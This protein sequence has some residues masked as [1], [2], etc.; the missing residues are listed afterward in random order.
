MSEALK[1]EKTLKEKRSN[2]IRVRVRYEAAQKDGHK[3]TLN[4]EGHKALRAALIDIK[5]TNPEAEILQ[6]KENAEKTAVNNVFA[7]TPKE[8]MK[9]I[10][11]PHNRKNIGMRRVEIG[12]R[13]AT[14]LTLDQFLDAS[15]RHRK[16]KKV[17]L[18]TRAAEMQQSHEA[19]AVCFCVSSSPKKF[20]NLLS[21]RLTGALGLEGKTIVEASWQ[22]ISSGSI[23]KKF[24]DAM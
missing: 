10:G 19:Y 6:W 5:K 16:E 8:S 21:E 12:I 14:N 1:G 18:F 4:M 7:L 11:L 24:S 22:T 23:G 2:E 13:I 20:L 17:W 9:Y 3:I 15:G